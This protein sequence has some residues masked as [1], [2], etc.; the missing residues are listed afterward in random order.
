VNERDPRTFTFALE[1]LAMQPTSASVVEVLV[2]GLRHPLAYVREG[3]L[4]GAASHL[5][6]RS[7][8]THVD[9]L[10]E[11]DPDEDIREMARDLLTDRGSP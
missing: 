10:A 11:N 5:R 4:L 7:V 3:A 1:E 8:L 6:D 2:R 9:D